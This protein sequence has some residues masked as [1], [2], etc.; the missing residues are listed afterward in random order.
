VTLRFLIFEPSY[1]RLQNHLDRFSGMDFI[2]MTPDRKYLHNGKE[3]ALEDVKAEAGWLNNDLFQSQGAMGG[4]IGGLMASPNLKWIQSSA[5]GYEHPIF[6]EFIKKGAI[7]STN[8]SQSVGM[9]EYVL[10]T[11]LD[12]F[13]RGP[14]RRAA[15]AESKWN[16]LKFREIMKTNWLIVGFGGIG[17]DVAKRARAFG[18]HITGVRRSKGIH[19]FAD[20]MISLEEIREHLP[21]ADVVVLCIP[22]SKA[23]TNLAD[24]KFFARMKKDAVLVNVGRGGLVDEEALHAALDKGT[25]EF[26]ILDV[27]KTEPLPSDSWIYKH[28][29][30]FMTPHASP[31]GTGLEERGGEVFVENLRRYLAGERLNNVADPKEVLGE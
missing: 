21:S 1:R 28:P 15:Q 31:D 30:I 9:S 27:F 14:E 16:R 18:A 10:A 19:E 8:H 24:A 5:A 13:Q 2:L 29:R 4:Y 25:P 22:L 26:A 11:V 7:L 3:I 23:T 6:G 12:H 20:R 17:Q